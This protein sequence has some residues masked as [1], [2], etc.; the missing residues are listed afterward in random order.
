MMVFGIRVVITLNNSCDDDA[1]VEIVA[2]EKDNGDKKNWLSSTHFWNTNDN[3]ETVEE[4]EEMR[5]V[6][7]RL[8]HLYYRIM[9][10]E[11]Y[12]G[13]MK[14]TLTVA[15]SLIGDPKDIKAVDW[16]NNVSLF[17]AVVIREPGKWQDGL[18]VQCVNLKS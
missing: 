15:I 14:T 5:A 3:L 10:A 18:I 7:I 17:L 2:N 6:I 4:K 12:S 8:L 11:K 16:S 9:S 13:G 1:K